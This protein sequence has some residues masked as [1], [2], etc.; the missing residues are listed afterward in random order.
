MR[1]LILHLPEDEGSAKALESRFSAIGIKALLHEYRQPW[2][3][4]L[5]SVVED[6][7][8]IVL[9]LREASLERKTSAF[10]LGFCLGKRLPLFAYML[11]PVNLPPLPSTVLRT[12]KIEEVMGYFSGEKLLWLEEE[13][14]NKA[15]HALISMG[16]G[17]GEDSMARV[18]AEGEIVPLQLYIDAGFSPDVRDKKGVPLICLAVRND[19]KAAVDLLLA[20]GADI[21]AVSMDRGNT[22]LM[23]A[24][25]E[26]KLEIMQLLVDAGASL[27][28]QSKSGQTALI[29]AVGQKAEDAASILLQAGADPYIKDALGMSAQ[30]Y[31][32]LFKLEM[33]LGQI[34]GDNGHG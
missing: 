34:E 18:T 33:V 24:A 19:H 21:D 11:E 27:N 15:K 9:L 30:K 16:L 29:L 14:R 10:I 25:A 22:A 4:L 28:V 12:G 32:S 3:N 8:H 7:S 23:D 17:I 13:R 2:D 6:A 5:L 20:S 1:L 26:H 31:A